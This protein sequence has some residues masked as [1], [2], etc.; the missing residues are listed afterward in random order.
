MTGPLVDNLKS[1]RSSLN[2]IILR[3]TPG[4]DVPQID[5]DELVR[6]RDELTAEINEIIETQFDASIENLDAFIKQVA[7]ENTKLT[8]A[9]GTIGAVKKGLDAAGTVLAELPGVLKFL[10]I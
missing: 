1:L 3:T 2:Q 10:G 8:A 4:K 5:F 6:R 9:A 7:A